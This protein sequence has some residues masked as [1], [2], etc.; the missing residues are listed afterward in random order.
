MPTNPELD[1][2]TREELI[3]RLK[4]VE[5]AVRFKIG[6]K[7]AV[8]V[9]GL[10]QRFPTTLYAASWRKLLAHGNELIAFMD[11]HERELAKEK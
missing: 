9:Y 4:Q 2:L 3:A 11:E 7:G 6:Q 10:G 5:S 8:S 1:K